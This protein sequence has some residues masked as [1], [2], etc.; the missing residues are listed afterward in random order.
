MIGMITMG[1]VTMTHI[2][3]NPMVLVNIQLLISLLAN[4][5]HITLSQFIPRIKIIISQLLVQATFSQLLVQ[6]TLSQPMITATTTTIMFSHHTSKIMTIATI[7]FSH[8][9]S[10]P[11]TTITTMSSHHTHKTITM[12]LSLLVLAN[13]HTTLTLRV[14]LGTTHTNMAQLDGKNGIDRMVFRVLLLSL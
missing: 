2:T 7:T 12:L 11:M 3:Y 5:T 1:S 8:H 10:N 9:T 13:L 6:A 4:P 14:L